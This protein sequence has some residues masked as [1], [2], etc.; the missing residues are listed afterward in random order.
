M[1]SHVL[2]Q[3]LTDSSKVLT[4]CIVRAIIEPPAF[5]I[6]QTS[7]LNIPEVSHFHFRGRENR[8]SQLLIETLSIGRLF[9]G[10]VSASEFNR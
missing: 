7:R 8:I 6:H 4:A 3:I 9:N 10:A 1:L 5:N 2:W